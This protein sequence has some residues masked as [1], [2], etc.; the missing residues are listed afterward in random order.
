[1]DC[2]GKEKSDTE[3]SVTLKD[4]SRKIVEDKKIVNQTQQEIIESSMDYSKTATVNDWDKRTYDINITASSKT[5]SS[6]VVTTGGIADVVMALDVS[7][8]MSYTQTAGGTNA[9][10]VSV[11]QY[12]N[13]RN[14]LKPNKI[15]YYSWINKYPMINVGNKWMYYN[16]S[17][18]KEINDSDWAYIYEWPSRITALKE[19]VNQF[20][21]NT[22]TSSSESNI[23]L[24]PF[25]TAVTN[26]TETLLN[27]DKNKD[28]LIK[29]VSRLS[30]IDGTSPHTALN[31]A[32]EL[33][34]NAKNPKYVI[35]F[36]DGE[37]TDP[38]DKWDKNY[39][40]YAEEA[41]KAL[42][43][44]GI[45][46]FTVGFA[47]SEKGQKFLAGDEY[48]L[49]KY[50][51][52]ASKG[53][54][55]NATNAEDL[56]KIFE[57]IQNTVTEPSA[58][59]NATIT[60]VIDPRFVILDKDGK[61]IT[62]D[63][64]KDGKT[65][66]VND[67][68][69]YL[70]AKGN[71]CIKWEGQTIPNKKE[72][73]AGNACWSK[74]I[75]VKAKDDY[76]GGNNVPTNVSPDS[77]ISTGYGDA[78]LPQPTVNVKADLTVDNLEKV[79]FLGDPTPT[80][81]LPDSM[82]SSILQKSKNYVYNETTKELE[83]VRVTRDDLTCSWAKDETFGN[84]KL[85]DLESMAEDYPTE[86]P[87]R[88][89][90][91]VTYNAGEPTATVGTKLGSTANTGGNIAGGETH[92][93]TAIN[94]DTKNYPDKEYG[95]YT[96]HIIK[97][98]IQITKKL[99]DAAKK[100]GTFTFNIYK[101]SA[102]KANL[103][104]TVTAAVGTGDTDAKFTIGDAKTTTAIVT[105][106]ARGEYIVQEVSQSGYQLL[107]ASND[108]KVTNCKSEK[109]K[110]IKF[111]IGTDNDN[112]NALEAEALKV[113]GVD[114]AKYAGPGCVGKVDYTNKE[115]V[116]NVDFVK[117][118]AADNNITINGAMFKLY[119]ADADWK[120]DDVVNDSV[121]SGENGAFGFEKLVPGNYLLIETKAATGYSL[122]QD[123]WKITVA[124]N[125]TVK[126]TKNNGMEIEATKRD[127]KNIYQIENAKVY[128]LPES[129]GPGTY[130]FT[131][132]GVAILATALL[133]FIN[134]KR[135]EEEA[136][137]S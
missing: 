57:T 96:I 64:L 3:V 30:V 69:V 58:I 106:L 120:Q 22:A 129:G 86:D 13:I 77:K 73:E 105:G 81:D 119:K 53:C 91:K 126:V 5:T 38:S 82:L 98:Q 84:D 79:I 59:Q 102:E 75:K 110:D 92:I 116:A 56:A 107:D 48:D 100:E 51:G 25:N 1:M 2:R 23:G 87:T 83:P 131:I 52:I 72:N 54:A 32:L 63:Q 61:A 93:V 47:L 74:S 66:Q 108:S 71:Q 44:K 37:P 55:F 8:S 4:S 122:P 27:V 43:D 136:K 104:T 14:S 113:E 35:L 123:P 36:T 118:D 101:G 78:I 103:V 109:S 10:Y 94:S 45:K 6:S 134:N 88:Y 46:V 19:V 11:G 80:A 132:S 124:E 65:V 133:L 137:R 135:R 17:S 89:Y 18:W 40:H 125:G 62:A 99:E 90:L 20:I 7:G 15:Y 60:D 42:K 115:T 85:T 31:K 127:D 12:N 111:T 26:A 121:K 95:V 39:Q 114:Y 41:A 130:G 33:L 34:N 76:I 21:R 112:K 16:N 24:A 67:G 50:P 70:D 128:S 97:G 49:T 117:V 9:R 28:A 29:N 68:T